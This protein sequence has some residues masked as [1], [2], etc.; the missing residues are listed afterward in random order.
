[1]SR[2]EKKKEEFVAL[3]GSKFLAEK[4]KIL[5]EL[6]STP[7]AELKRIIEDTIS[8]MDAQLKRARLLRAALVRRGEDVVDSL[9]YVPSQNDA[10]DLIKALSKLA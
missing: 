10:Q 4:E 8:K 9:P 7:T 5:K 2:Q 1:M 6:E 3:L